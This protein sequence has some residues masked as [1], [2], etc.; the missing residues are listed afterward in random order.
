MSKLN[1]LINKLCPNGTEFV[2]LNKLLNYIQP[3]P[4]IVESTEYDDSYDTPVLTAGQTFILGYTNEINGIF[5]ADET[6]PVI[7]FDDFTTSFHWVD[8]D[9]KVKSSAMKFLRPIENNNVN[10]KYIYY[11]MK[12]LKY[13]PKDHT[14]QWIGK[15]SCLKVPLPPIEIQ[16]EIV[17]ILDELTELTQ[18]LITELKNEIDKR[19]QQ[20]EYYRDKLLSFKELK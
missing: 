15:Y 2:E 6:N 3:G 1:D 7:I 17:A 14:R 20:Y 13:S 11:S 10:F 18:E 8:F 4:Y 5:K 16:N 12:S 9:F 19:K